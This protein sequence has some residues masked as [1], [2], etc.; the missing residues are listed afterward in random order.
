MADRWVAFAKTGDPNHEVARERWR[1]WRYELDEGYSRD[2]HS[3]REWQLEDLDRILDTELADEINN[4]TT[5]ADDASQEWSND[6]Q[7]QIYRRRALEA[8][9]M[10]VV[11]H[12]VF[13][14]MLR[15][16]KKREDV[17][18]FFSSFLLGNSGRNKG[19]PR[20][21]NVGR[22]VRRLQQ[23]AQEMGVIGTGLRGE[24][25]R[26]SGK[27]AWEEDFFPEILE[28]K[29]PPEGRLVERDCTCDFWDKIRYRY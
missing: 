7:V 3:S 18:S 1:P 22:A 26:G 19:S 28:L 15:R 6:P 4:V 20:A 29:W 24:A 25:R 16:T 5:A 17:E 23:I 2:K 8:L 12:D 9:G 11:E 21:E 27:D 13:Q 10:Q 14:T